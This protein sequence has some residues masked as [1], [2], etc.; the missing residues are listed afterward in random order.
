MEIIPVYTTEDYS[1]VKWDIGRAVGS[2]PAL[3]SGS[4][5]CPVLGWSLQETHKRT[6]HSCTL[7]GQGDAVCPSDCHTHSAVII[8]VGEAQQGQFVIVMFA[9]LL[10]G[11]WNAQGICWKEKQPPGDCHG[12]DSPCTSASLPLPTVALRHW[13][14]CPVITL[15]AP[16]L[17]PLLRPQQPQRQSFH[18]LSL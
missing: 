9:V 15:T 10:L 4:T 13:V 5:V 16:L 6:R 18:F 7:Q 1:W 14:S 2:S 17:F 3:C 11:F 8:E 12:E